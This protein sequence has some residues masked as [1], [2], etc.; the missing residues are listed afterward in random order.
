VSLI[1]LIGFGIM[2]S[3]LGFAVSAGLVAYLVTEE[4]LFKI[5]CS[6][7]LVLVNLMP[8]SLLYC[9][10]HRKLGFFFRRSKRRT[11]VRLKTRKEM[12]NV[13]LKFWKGFVMKLPLIIVMAYQLRWK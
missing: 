1:D 12:K 4:N 9:P 10:F 3:D 11:T 7:P 5:S 6:L 13:R 2:M 8:L